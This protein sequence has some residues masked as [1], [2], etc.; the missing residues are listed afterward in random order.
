LSERSPR[1]VWLGLGLD[2][3]RDEGA[4]FN[5][6]E[7]TSPKVR[8]AVLGRK[9]KPGKGKDRDISGKRDARSGSMRLKNYLHAIA[10]VCIP[11]HVYLACG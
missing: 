2:Y 6:E 1:L 4:C 10:K 7:E 11:C 9:V 5:V 8:E 3:I